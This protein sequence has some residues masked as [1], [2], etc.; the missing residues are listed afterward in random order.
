M[1][2]TGWPDGTNT[3][4][5]A[6]TT[7]TPYYGTLIIN[8]PGAVISGLDIHG[9][10]VINAPNVTLENNKITSTSFY[11]VDVK[12]GGAIVR[13]NTIDGVGTGND[14]SIGINGAGTFI[15]N[16]IYNVENG[17]GIGGSNTVIRD[18]YVHDLKASGSPHY[19][20]IQIDGNAYNVTISHNTIIVDHNQTSAVMID[21]WAGPISNVTVD[22]N[23]LVGGGYTIYVDGQFGGGSI[24]D[25]RITNNHMGSGGFGVTNFNKTSPVYTGNVNDGSSIVPLLNTSANQG[26]GTTTPTPTVPDAPTLASFSNDSGT[27]G[28]GITN[29]NTLTFSGK[30]AA[31]GTVKVFDG[32][33]Q[34]GTATANSSG[35]WSFTT[36]ALSDGKHAFTAQVTDSSGNTSVASSALSVTIDTTPPP[37]PSIA[38]SAAARAAASSS[39]VALQGTAEG[40]SS[41]SVYD[42]STKIGTVKADANGVWSFSADSLSSGDH[43]F[44]ARAADAAGNTGAASTAVVVN[45]S[46][47]ST[48]GS[49]DPGTPSQPAVPT[50]VSFSNDTGKAG[51]N[52]TSDNTLTLKGAASA[53]S[54]IKVYDGNKLVGTTTTDKDG[55]WSLTTSALK[56]G[57][58]ALTAKA[59][60]TDGQ[61]GSASAALAVTIDTKA[62][63][64]P[65]LAVYP[66]DGGKAVSGST[67]LDHLMLKGTAEANSTVH[68][69]DG[70]T[71]IATV[72]ADSKGAWNYQTGDLA[73]GAHNFSAKAMDLAG[74]LSGASS[75]KTVSVET[76]V[77]SPEPSTPV[78]DNSAPPA[79]SGGSGWFGGFGGFGGRG[80]FDGWGSSHSSSTV[81]DW[82]SGQS[83]S[84]G[85]QSGG[86]GGG[87]GNFIVGT[88]GRDTLVSTS[89][90]DLM[91]GRGGS[92]TFVFSANFGNDVI[93][94]F[95]AS[96]WGHDVVRFSRSTFDGFADVLSHA[97]QAGA[98][99]VITASAADSLTFKNLKL[100]DLNKGD[101]S[102]G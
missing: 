91:V 61:T 16:N 28:D 2:T 102:F 56:D 67:A 9:S 98:D 57:S 73:D 83:S 55:A 70:S 39:S 80:G 25:V 89:G 37:A 26:G 19:D 49:G 96:G 43:S 42:G 5:P 74:N 13:N 47:S 76:P 92:D 33:K 32:G 3:G 14:G 77:T 46:G 65:T 51:D 81:T 31:S 59:V 40:N 82:F 58:H 69:Y 24:T 87:F 38:T 34:I 45:V 71:K 44:T 8:T 62:P 60:G 63:G 27:V 88:N 11:V 50:I 22:N 4:V 68:V 66:S 30:A 78:V 12:A 17:F 7:L 94:D 21:N 18:N 75:Q 6:G 64:A 99:V 15:G 41:V 90:N 35:N 1:A 72:A 36:A 86:F 54:T 100:A 85:G 101:F 97:A 95:Q 52:V 48:G 23:L 93:K 20:G 29:D 79:S 84:S 10:V 53:N